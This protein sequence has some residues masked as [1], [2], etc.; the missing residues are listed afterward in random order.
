MKIQMRLLLLPLLILILS[1]C[2]GELPDSK[3]T[4]ETGST[5]FYEYQIG[6]GYGF[7]GKKVLAWIDG[8]EVLSLVGTEEIETFAQ[9]QGTYML[10]SGSSPNKQITVL[11]TVDGTQ[12]HEQILDLSTGSYL[13]IYLNQGQISIFNTPFL[14]LE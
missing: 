14:I 4:Q 12:S 10:V 1:A 11:V 2:S 13:H 5:A 3:I 8:E 9:M 7:E 6:L